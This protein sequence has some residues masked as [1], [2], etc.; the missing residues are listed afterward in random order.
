MKFVEKHR[1]RIKEKSKMLNCLLLRSP[2][3]DPSRDAAS[4]PARTLRLWQSLF[5]FTVARNFLTH[6]YSRAGGRK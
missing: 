6:K 1:N 2:S 3:V 5:A 4:L